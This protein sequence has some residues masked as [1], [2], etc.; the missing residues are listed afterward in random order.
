L[1]AEDRALVNRMVPIPKTFIPSDPAKTVEYS[2]PPTRDTLAKKLGKRGYPWPEKLQNALT[3]VESAAKQRIGQIKRQMKWTKTANQLVS[4]LGLK[5]HKVL[6]HVAKLTQEIKD[7]LGKK[8]KI[9]N[10]Q[11]QDKLVK[12][13]EVTHKNLKKVRRQTHNIRKNQAKMIHHK[14]ELAHALEGIKRSLAILKGMKRKRQFPQRGAAKKMLDQLSKFDPDMS[15]EKEADEVRKLQ[16]PDMVLAELESEANEEAMP[17]EV[18]ELQEEM[19]Q[20]EGTEG[21]TQDE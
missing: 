3:T 15:F 11:L 6:K 9:Q 5:N 10:K 8:K 17:E 7:L 18:Q 12:R 14:E 13:L 19:D 1:S 16:F 21:E 4:E 20:E 2:Y